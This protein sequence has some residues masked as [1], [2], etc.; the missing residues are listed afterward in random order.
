LGDPQTAE[1]LDLAA[2]LTNVLDECRMVLPGVQALFGFQL[3]AVFNSTFEAKLTDTEQKLHL[4]AIALVVIAIALVMAP[5][6][7]HQQTEPKVASSRFL[8]V[9]RRL[10]LAAM[11]PLAAG[12]SLDVFLVAKIIC[13]HRVVAG[14]VACTLFAI[15]ITLWFV[16]PHFYRSKE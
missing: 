8:R 13:H 7:L 16:Y 12:I 1:R 9:S 3:I 15:L 5:A 14:A 2:A 11:A 4:L 10:L 6:S